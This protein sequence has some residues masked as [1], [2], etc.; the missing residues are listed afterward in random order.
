MSFTLP[1]FPLLLPFLLDRQRAV[2][3]TVPPVDRPV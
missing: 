3:V 2:A 1:L